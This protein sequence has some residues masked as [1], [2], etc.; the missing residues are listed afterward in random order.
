MNDFLPSRNVGP[1][2]GLLGVIVGLSIAT[3]WQSFS[4]Q[5]Q[6][7]GTFN[8]KLTCVAAN[9]GRPDGFFVLNANNAKT[10][11]VIVPVPGD[12]VCDPI[13]TATKNT[14]TSDY[15]SKTGGFIKTS[16]AW[17][18]RDGKEYGA[19]AI[20][21]DFYSDAAY[22]QGYL[23]VYFKDP[24]VA[25]SATP[26]GSIMFTPIFTKFNS[27]E[28]TSSNGAGSVVI[29]NT[30]GQL[31][32]SVNSNDKN[33]VYV[34]AGTSPLISVNYKLVARQ[35][36]V[37]V[38]QQ[39]FDYN[40]NTVFKKVATGSSVSWSPSAV[41]N[42]GTYLLSLCPVDAAGKILPRATCAFRSFNIV[43]TKTD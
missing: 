29:D 3:N 39:I 36:G 5:T 27:V 40:N 21:Y 7:A 19:D 30:E 34:E 38:L 25:G 18:G 6:V 37:R 32:V 12:G 28:I 43:D 4:Q 2:L 15:G 1:L 31:P 14:P 23:K 22:P 17:Y 8:L 9:T 35:E 11:P 26:A 24:S 13:I 16:G 41:E 33:I 42:S 20:G 10:N